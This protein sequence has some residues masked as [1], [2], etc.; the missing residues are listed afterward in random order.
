ME[1]KEKESKHEIKE[2]ET[3]KKGKPPIKHHHM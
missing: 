2:K 3:E 1:V